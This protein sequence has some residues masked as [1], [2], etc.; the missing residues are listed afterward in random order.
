VIRKM[1]FGGLRVVDTQVLTMLERTVLATDIHAW[2]KFYSGGGPAND[3]SKLTPFNA[4][5]TANTYTSASGKTIRT[6]SSIARTVKN[7]TQ[8]TRNSS[9]SATATS[10]AHGFAVGNVVLIQGA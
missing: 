6:V 4:S 2:A 5:S 9:T 7:V 8:I 1:L 3:I 10:T